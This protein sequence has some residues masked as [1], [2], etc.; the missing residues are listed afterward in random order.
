MAKYKNTTEYILTVPGIGE[1]EPGE[2][3][4]APEGFHNINFELVKEK[5]EA[6]K[7]IKNKEE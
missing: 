6:K 5:V 2:I 3:V 1:V 7:E 4:E